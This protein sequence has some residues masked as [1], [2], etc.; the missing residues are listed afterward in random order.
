LTALGDPL[1]CRIGTQWGVMKTY[2]KPVL[3]KREKLSSV[4]AAIPS[5]KH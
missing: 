1:L 4:T 3:T 5:S 2:Q